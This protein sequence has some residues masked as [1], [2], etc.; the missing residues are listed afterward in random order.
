[1]EKWIEKNTAMLSIMQKIIQEHAV[2]RKHFCGE[3]AEGSC[4]T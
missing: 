2:P 1:M 3:A 4:S